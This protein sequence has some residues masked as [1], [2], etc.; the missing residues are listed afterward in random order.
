MNTDV[1]VGDNMFPSN[2]A[3]TEEFDTIVD[4]YFLVSKPNK[5]EKGEFNFHK[6]VKPLDLCRYLI[7]LTTREGDVVLDPF[8]GSGTTVLAAKNMSRK[9]IGIDKNTEYVDI[10]NKRL[11]DGNFQD[12]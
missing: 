10:T 6:T 5:K 2:V 12:C 4:R 8:V 9:Y 3:S 11:N 7:A 1:K